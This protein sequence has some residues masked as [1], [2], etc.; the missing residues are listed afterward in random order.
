VIAIGPNLPLDVYPGGLDIGISEHGT[1]TTIA[2]Q[3]EWDLAS[4]PASREAIRQ[5]LDRYPE[6][7]VLDLR[8]LGFID[9]GGLH[10]AIELQRRA[11][12][13]NARLVI[14]PGSRAVQRLFE[15][16]QLSE[17]LPFRLASEI[18]AEAVVS[19]QT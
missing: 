4:A 3:G 6:R 14:L 7:V 8:S 15:I 1:T 12:R 5:A 10:V 19:P 9:S 11:A 2:L 16:C 18:P 17:V 13:Q